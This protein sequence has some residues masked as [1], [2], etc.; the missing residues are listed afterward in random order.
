MTQEKI[1]TPEVPMVISIRLFPPF[2]MALEHEVGKNGV[3]KINILPIG[4]FIEC[5]KGE[6]TMYSPTIPYIYKEIPKVIIT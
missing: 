3:T 5:K 4:T 1:I 6:I 2:G